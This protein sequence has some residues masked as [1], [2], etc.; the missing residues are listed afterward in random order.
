MKFKLLMLFIFLFGAVGCFY[1]T[2]ASIN[3]EDRMDILE[4]WMFFIENDVLIEDTSL[5]P[6]GEWNSEQQLEYIFP[7]LNG[8]KCP[9]CGAELYDSD[10]Y[11]VYMGG[12]PRIRIICKECG[13]V[14]NRVK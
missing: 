11:V 1:T 13:Y 5:I 8:I 9:D 10:G 2:K 7:Q 3:L 4:D 14:G 6:L 12:I